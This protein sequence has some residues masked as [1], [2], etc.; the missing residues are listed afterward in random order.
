[1]GSE[2]CIRDRYE[3]DNCYLDYAGDGYY[4][5]DTNYPGIAIAVTVSF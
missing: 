4:L 1:M 2:M 5:Y 3:T